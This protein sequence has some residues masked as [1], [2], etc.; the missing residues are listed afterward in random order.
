MISDLGAE[1]GLEDYKSG[2]K[3][4]L[5]DADTVA[6]TACLRHEYA[7]D[8]L[9][10]D[11]YSDSEWDTLINAPGYD[12]QDGCIWTINVEEATQSA[13]EQIRD[14][15]SATDTKSVEA[16]FTSGRNFRYEVYPMYKGNR[17]KTRYPTGISQVKDELHKMYPGEI[18]TEY[19]AD[20]IVVMLK[21]TQPKKYVL[22]AIDKDVYKSVQGKHY[23]YYYSAKYGIEPKW[24]ETEAKDAYQFPY[25]QTLMGDSTDNIRGCPGIGPKKAEKALAG[26]VTP[27]DMWRA[28][29]SLFISKKLTIKDA[30]QDMR[31]VNMHQLGLDKNITLWEPPC[32]LD[33]IK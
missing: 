18:C 10:R 6:Y 16:Y 23:N 30:M 2:N 17:A 24:V 22:A 7:D 8:L 15:Q 33:N 12:E 13:I 9:P 20:D 4:L 3:I 21:R 31:L 29:V 26:L 1:E 27:C 25:L 28:V 11:M 32:S 19:E 14:I 5:L